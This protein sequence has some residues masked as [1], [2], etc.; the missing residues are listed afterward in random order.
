MKRKIAMLSFILLSILF[1]ANLNQTPV[2]A[3]YCSRIINGVAIPVPC[4]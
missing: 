2:E 3:D 4:D 1:I